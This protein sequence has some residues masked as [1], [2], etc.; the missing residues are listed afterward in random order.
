M[1][2]IINNIYKIYQ[3]KGQKKETSQNIFTH[4]CL[5]KKITSK[6]KLV[7]ELKNEKS[8]ALDPKG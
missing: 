5:K 3:K 1:H 8:C 7:G 2:Q 4:A 6:S